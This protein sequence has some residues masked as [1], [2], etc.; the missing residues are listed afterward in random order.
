M[1]TN[2]CNLRSVPDNRE[3][4]SGNKSRIARFGSI[5]V[6]D[7]NLTIP[8]R[9]GAEIPSAHAALTLR[10]RRSGE[11]RSKRNDST[12]NPSGACIGS[13]V[14][15]TRFLQDGIAAIRQ[16]ARG[17]MGTLR[18]DMKPWNAAQFDLNRIFLILRLPYPQSRQSLHKWHNARVRQSVVWSP[19][20]KTRNGVLWREYPS[21]E[22]RSR[23][24][25]SPSTSEPL[26]DPTSLSS[27]VRRRYGGRGPQ[28]QLCWN[29]GP[30]MHRRIGR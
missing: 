13:I 23:A 20:A 30:A 3:S 29:S 5:R 25:I 11:S 19:V 28:K 14:N 24:K 27:E 7:R 26:S 4:Q 9:T 12:N 2:R 15:A 1:R 6:K 8:E 21:F 22:T 18:I 16:F 10:I 17:F